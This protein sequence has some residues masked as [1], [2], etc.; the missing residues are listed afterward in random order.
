MRDIINN[1]RITNCIS[2]LKRRLVEQSAS[3]WRR[4]RELVA[5]ARAAALALTGLHVAT[6][7]MDFVAEERFVRVCSPVNEQ[8]GAALSRFTTHRF[9]QRAKVEQQQCSDEYAFS[10]QGL[11]RPCHAAAR[12]R[13]RSARLRA[14][15]RARCALRNI[16]ALLGSRRLLLDDNADDCNRTNCLQNDRISRQP[17]RKHLRAHSQLLIAEFD[18]HGTARARRHADADS[19]ADARS[20]RRIESRG[21]E[22]ATC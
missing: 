6:R 5:R 21:T 19:A 18:R 16:F 22:F 11:R 14:H 15:L 4:R 20:R 10:S 2:T 17:S 7:P 13:A 8:R 1:F 3:V 12:L 9:C